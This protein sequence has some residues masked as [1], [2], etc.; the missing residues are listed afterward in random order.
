M[1]V[2]HYAQSFSLVSETFIYD[3][4]K[5]LERQD[6]ENHVVTHERENAEE[7]PFPRVHV[8]DHPGRWHPRRVYNRILA[9][10]G[11][12]KA[13]T[14]KWPQ[15]RDRLQRA[16]QQIEPDVI[17]AQFGPAGVLI[18]PVAA[19]VNTPLVVSFHGYDVSILAQEDF[20]I[21]KY[22]ALFKQADVLHTVSS[23]I[24]ERVEQLGGPA[25]RI[26]VVHNGIR[27]QRFQLQTK[28]DTNQINSPIQ[29]LHVG[30]LVEKK[31]PVHLI[32]AFKHAQKQLKD[33][34]LEL[35]IAGDG[36]LRTDAEQEASRLGIR[37]SVSFEGWVP[38]D[39][40]PQLMEES[41]IYTMHCVTASDGDQE[42][43]GVTFAEASAMNLPI[44][45]T[46]HN[47]IP[48]VV[49]D[50]ETGYLVPEKDVVAMGD[51]ISKL[52]KSKRLRRRMGK[53]GRNYIKNN[54]DL[55]DQTEKLKG[56]YKNI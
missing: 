10:F 43:M 30:R 32:R 47:G 5:E 20:W 28:H 27:L 6:V 7:R 19:A 4:V 24:A 48:D 51:M 9:A 23:H 41:D 21:E 40:V 56:V 34:S 35:V 22:Q 50:G 2:L 53:K 39:A 49:V 15:I 13:R 17:H 54:F 46:R 44:V 12:G 11:M 8:V 14:S 36:P 1:R 38:H 52:S 31:A 3:L 25:S 37:N 42:G 29:C 16:I 55:V 45:T 33:A 18:G 26:H